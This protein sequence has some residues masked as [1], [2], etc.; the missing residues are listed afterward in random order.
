MTEPSDQSDRLHPEAKA[1]QASATGAKG[2]L[3]S[4]EEVLDL[5][6]QTVA[7]GRPVLDAVTEAG[8]LSPD[9]RRQLEAQRPATT[10]TKAQL[11][12]MKERARL[13][14]PVTFQVRPER[15]MSVVDLPQGGY[16]VVIAV[17]LDAASEVLAAFY[18]ADA[19][20]HEI[21]SSEASFV[22]SVGSLRA[23]FTGVPDG[24]DI[25]IGTMHLTRAP[26]LAA[27]PDADV[28]VLR[29]PFALDLVRDP[30]GG[31][32]TTVAQLIGT[33]QLGVTAVA[34]VATQLVTVSAEI[35]APADRPASV[36]LIEV[37][38]S[39]PLQPRSAQAL[40]G[41]AAGVE[42]NLYLGLRLALT[43]LGPLQICPGLTVP[44][45]AGVTLRIQRA[46]VRVRPDQ[47]SGMLLV[48]VLI[49]ATRDPADGIGDPD[50]LR[51]PPSMPELANVA[52][53][54]DEALLHKLVRQALDSGELQA[55]VDR[56]NNTGLKVKVR[57]AEVEVDDL[58]VRIRLKLKAN[59]VCF[60]FKDVEVRAIHEIRI[61]GV[62]DG[63][64]AIERSTDTNVDDVD[65][66]VC[67]VV[68]ALEL[69]LAS[70]LP[71]LFVRRVWRYIGLVGQFVGGTAG[72][73]STSF[74]SGMI[75][76]STPLPGTELLPTVEV[77]QASITDT[78]G[79]PNA[80]LATNGSFTLRPDEEATY[81][82]LR[83]LRSP[84]KVAPGA[85]PQ[86][87]EGVRVQV[88]DQD[89]PRP[90]GDDTTIP[91]D[92]TVATGNQTVIES[93][94]FVPPSEDQILVAGRTGGDGEVQLRMDRGVLDRA[95]LAGQVAT[96]TTTLH[97]DV[98][99]GPPSRSRPGFPGSS[100][101]VGGGGLGGGPGGHPG[102][103]VLGGGPGGHPGGGPG[104]GSALGETHTSERLLQ[105][106]RPDLYF[107]LTMP[108]G[109]QVDTRNL[110]A[111]FF[112]NEPDQHVGTREDPV[113]FLVFDQQVVA[114]G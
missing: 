52:A 101:A 92:T 39:S 70:I 12:T 113:V 86:P 28:G 6:G 27:A 98:L 16:D 74:I 19:L 25:G 11:A 48:G 30:A 105:E 35:A 102:G 82:Y 71:A 73:K 53:R 94:R 17:R 103:G 55:A 1:E 32:A 38:E 77:L 43:E 29:V 76:S 15:A 44:L 84:Q 23:A 90:A 107:L 69:A 79:V 4:I 64:V 93:H 10:F 66:A 62:L 21:A 54:V 13:G 96:T 57:D 89:V 88:V 33:V 3:T 49:G 95:R 67:G 109:R 85:S 68:A 58:V 7:Q 46:D 63:Q 99:P 20:P 80:A 91:E 31:P 24:D 60:E 2:R 45:G 26:S 81:L 112:L 83:V 59:D 51:I 87:V 61:T 40:R 18:D 5:A 36:S 22:F 8:S 37:A 108:D 34:A 100:G 75:S 56:E 110:D 111:G 97:H 78:A 72:G 14:G 106:R 114:P 50:R 42:E 9:L 41:F 47:Q 65:M 104:G